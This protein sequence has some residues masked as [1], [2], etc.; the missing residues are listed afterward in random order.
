VS[1][2]LTLVSA[3]TFLSFP[4][5]LYYMSAYVCVVVVVLQF[6]FAFTRP[7]ASALLLEYRARDTSS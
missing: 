5:Q 7:L 4:L 1:T 6:F 3:A 2:T